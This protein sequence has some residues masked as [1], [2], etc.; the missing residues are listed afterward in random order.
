[1]RFSADRE[2]LLQAM[3]VIVWLYSTIN[4]TFLCIFLCENID[5]HIMP[6]EK[7][8]ICMLAME[9]FHNFLLS[10]IFFFKINYFKKKKNRNTIIVPNSLD[11]DQARHFV[12]PDLGPNCLPKLSADDKFATSRHTVN[13]S[14]KLENFKM[15]LGCLFR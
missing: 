2:P 10:A 15:T 8:T 11:P 6:D 14:K 7:L 12:G 5:R 4:A 9:I 3:I 13:S 1:M